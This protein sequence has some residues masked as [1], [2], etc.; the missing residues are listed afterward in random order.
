MYD[1]D[2]STKKAVLQ[3]H[4]KIDRNLIPVQA[5]LTISFLTTERQK[6]YN[7]SLLPINLISLLKNLLPVI[8]LQHQMLA[9]N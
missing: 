8:V 1:W 4:S 2:K 7:Y 3:S 9:P 5:N 6:V